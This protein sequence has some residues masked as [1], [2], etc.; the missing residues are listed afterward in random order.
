MAI[1]TTPTNSSPSAVNSIIRIGWL[2]SICTYPN[3]SPHEENILMAKRQLI[4]LHLEPIVAF[5]RNAGAK[6]RTSFW[7]HRTPPDRATRE[8]QRSYVPFF[9]QIQFEL[10]CRR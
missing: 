1:T 9:H 6:N 4:L 2:L 7:T 10:E 3:N 5:F 8:V